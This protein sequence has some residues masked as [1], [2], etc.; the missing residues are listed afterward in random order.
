MFLQ[1]RCLPKRPFLG[2][3]GSPIVAKSD[4]PAPCGDYLAG[5]WFLDVGQRTGSSSFVWGELRR[6]LP[7]Y[8]G[9]DHAVHRRGAGRLCVCCGR[10]NHDNALLKPLNCLHRF[11]S[12]RRWNFRLTDGP[13][14]ENILIVILIII[15]P[16]QVR[17]KVQK[18][19]SQK[20]SRACA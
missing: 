6:L 10:L 19:A 11:A 1:G 4:T 15:V 12:D 2:S 18:S 17:T 3:V 5:R 7:F 8:D 14:G 16:S 20:H 13:L 9:A